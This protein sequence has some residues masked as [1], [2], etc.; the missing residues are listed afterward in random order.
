MDVIENPAITK[1]TRRVRTLPKEAEPF[2]WKPGQSGNP[3]GRPSKDLASDAAKLVFEGLDALAIS[4][5]WRKQIE[6]NPKM[7]LVLAERAYG[8]L[9]IPIEHSSPLDN[10]SEAELREKLAELRAKEKT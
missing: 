6:K 9:K 2:K 5:I 7:L 8:K 1:K 10:M 4:K 3:S